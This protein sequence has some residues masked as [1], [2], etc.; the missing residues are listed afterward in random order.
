M[1]SIGVNGI[2][3]RFITNIYAV[4]RCGKVLKKMC[5]HEPRKHGEYLAVGKFLVHR[6]V[7]EMWLDNFDPKMHVHHKDRNKHNNH[8]DN[9]ECL[10]VKEHFGDRHAGEFGVYIRSE[11]TR[12]KLRAYRTGRKMPDE[13]K[14]KIRASSIGKSHSYPA[15]RKPYTEESKAQRSQ[16]HVR[17]TTCRVLGV[18]YRSFAEASIATN[19][20]RFTIRKRCLSKNFPEYE[21]LTT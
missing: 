8:A 15:E 11:E 1:G 9:L 19:I 12:A 14:E 4:S 21:I 17:N 20:H 18:T 7:A 16:N 6:M 5:P 3:Y 2:V 10:T 13:V